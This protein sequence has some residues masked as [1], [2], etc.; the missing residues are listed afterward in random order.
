MKTIDGCK[1]SAQKILNMMDQK[2]IALYRKKTKDI[3][4]SLLMKI[5]LK[6]R[7]SIMR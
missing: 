6:N 1:N 2:E 5:R 7:L 3:P 4:K